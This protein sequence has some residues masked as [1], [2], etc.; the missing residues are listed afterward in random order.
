MQH[1][2]SAGRVWC[3]Y[4]QKTLPSLRRGFSSSFFQR[5]ENID[6]HARACLEK[7]RNIGIIAHI[8][9]VCSRLKIPFKTLTIV[10]GKTTTTE[11]M[12]YY[13]GHTRRIGSM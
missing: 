12:L 2:A 8:D 5:A 6:T 13:S 7:T 1:G 4:L 10:Q 11:R 9:A 3:S